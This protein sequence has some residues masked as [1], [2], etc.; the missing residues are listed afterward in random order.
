L[1]GGNDRPPSDRGRR[2][3][4]GAC[5]AVP[6]V[7]G[8]ALAG[9]RVR[10]AL[11]GAGPLADGRVEL[12]AGGGFPRLL[13]GPA[14]ESWTLPHPPRRIVSTYLAADEIL[15]ELVS[16]DRLAAVSIF[17]DD[18]VISNVAG[19]YPRALPRVRG[20]VEGIL[21]LEPDLICV[22]GYSDADA[23]RL[24]VGAGLPILRWSRFDTFADVLA[25]VRLIGAAVGADVRA[26]AI[27]AAAEAKLAALAARLGGV[28]PVRVLYLDPPSFT[29]GGHTLMDEILTRAGC[30]NVAAEA[31]I[32]GAG[33]IGVETALSL[34]AEAIVVP[35]VAGGSPPL[36]GLR[37]TPLWRELPAVRAG[38]VQAIS[39]ALPGDVSQRAADAPA[40]VARLLHPERFQTR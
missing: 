17:A 16:L 19:V 36:D 10:A 8:A 37:A 24:A 6:L 26:E 28:R 38:R 39:A 1:S 3:A 12:P 31:G 23:M 30:V 5:L 35:T 29:A 25:N 13:R 14:G 27:A 33:Q 7:A 40:A 11:V 34:E 21:A 22:A 4:L 32:V 18:P 2:L 9:R 20:E 15:A